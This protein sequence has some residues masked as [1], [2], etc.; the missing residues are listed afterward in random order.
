MKK[1]LSFLKLKAIQLFLFFIM[2]FS[3]LGYMVRA[4]SVAGDYSFSYIPGQTY[5]EFLDGN[6]I[7]SNDWDNF[8]PVN[9]SLGFNFYFNGSTYTNCYINDN[10]YITFGTTAP[11]NSDYYPI[12][13]VRSY[14]GAIAAF[15][16]DLFYGNS[17]NAYRIRYKTTVVSGLKVFTV[18]WRDARRYNIAGK[19]NFQIKLYEGS[20][21][22]EVHYGGNSDTSNNTPLTVQVGLRGTSNADFNNRTTT[23]DW[24]TTTAGTA[25]NSTNSTTGTIRP[26]P[27]S[28]YRWTLTKFTAS[29]VLY[30][31]GTW[32]APCGPN[33]ITVEAW[34]AGGA[35]GKAA[36][37]GPNGG[38]GG[39]A[40]S[41][42]TFTV[43]AGDSFVYTVGSGGSGGGRN[44]SERD[45][46]DSWFGS[47]SIF[48]AKAGIGVRDDVY[49]GGLGG[50]ASESVGDTTYSGG[51]GGT[52]T[53]G[54]N[55]SGGGGGAA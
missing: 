22:V 31:S 27:N 7:G 51:N 44:N 10:G 15:A 41:K 26:I 21:T 42:K 32:T 9:A 45:G 29:T 36:N 54:G 13:S 34:G 1:Q 39:G 8:A 33:Q 40:Y 6:T 37:A 47:P 5:T 48:L 50:K 18:Q 24:A 43:S 16:R 23:T 20:N 19:F 35:G 53:S 52:P 30:G 55:H 28:I 3:F 38:G 49:T 12:S 25:N 46:K 2:L 4:Q 17:S 11:V 14:D